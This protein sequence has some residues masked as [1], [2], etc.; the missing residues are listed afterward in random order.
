MKINTYHRNKKDDC[1]KVCIKLVFPVGFSCIAHDP[2][3]LT[4]KHSY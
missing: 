4:H 3:T 1:E 2:L